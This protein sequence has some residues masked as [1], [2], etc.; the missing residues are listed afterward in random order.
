MLIASPTTCQ[1]HNSI[2]LSLPLCYCFRT[3]CNDSVTYILPF[4]F[5]LLHQPLLIFC[6]AQRYCTKQFTQKEQVFLID[7]SKLELFNF[8]V[9]NICYMI[10][11]VCI[12][13][14]SFHPEFQDLLILQPFHYIF[15][16]LDSSLK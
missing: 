16:E 3:L 12:L 15:M 10:L 13:K 4:S 7:A 11:N 14:T 6:M 1:E 9:H 8:S 2:I 5:H